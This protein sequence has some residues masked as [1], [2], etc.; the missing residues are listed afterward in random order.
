MTTIIIAFIV[1]L[2]VLI[3]FHELGHFLV[4]R[5]CGV[6]VEKFSLG[7]GPR[8]I[9]K[10]VGITD[11]RISA[12]PLGGYVKM[13]GDEP[14]AELDPEL[15]PLSFTHKHVF[16]R[17]LIVAAGP[18]FNLLLA[19]MIYTGFFV[20]VGTEDIRPVVRHV[21]TGG[22]AAIAG[23]QT[24]D[25]ITAIDG[26]PVTA[27]GDIDKLVAEAKGSRLH[28]SVVRDGEVIDFTIEPQAKVTKDIL[29]DDLPYYDVGCSGLAPLA[30]I[31]GEVADG[32][33]AKAMGVRKGDRIVAINDQ[34]VDSWRTMTTLISGSKGA[35]LHVRL[36]RAGSVIN[37][38]IVPIRFSEENLLGEQV[39][40]YRIGISTPGVTIPDADRITIKRGFFQA[41]AESIAQTYQISRLMVL[42]IGK[43]IKGTVSTKT[44]GGP[45]MI[46]EMAG[47]QAEEGLTHLIFFIAWLSINLAVINFLPIPVLDGGHL[48]FFF[49]EAIMRRPL[50]TRMRE[51]A[52][53]AGI[54]ILIMLMVF[55]FYNDISRIFSS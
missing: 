43:L 36:D 6:G 8:L 31:V 54:F 13:V 14:D 19:V 26:R 33:P 12:I 4:A 53:Q 22:P 25:R 52:Q 42:S 41:V 28:F 15:L 48:L 16:K 17:I 37:V 10:T 35:P 11:Y 21:E 20:F 29:G 24:G 47:Q 5:L 45:I 44:L 3:F 27:W 23:L 1:V 34:P 32:Y 50:N 55:V 46:A 39:E 7:F 2:G 30:A 38:E 9:G 18:F 49:I 40:S 51:M